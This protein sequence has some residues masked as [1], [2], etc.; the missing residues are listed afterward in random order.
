MSQLGTTAKHVVS[1]AL[2]LSL[3]QCYVLSSNGTH[4]SQPKIGKELQIAHLWVVSQMPHSPLNQLT[5]SLAHT[6][7]LFK[8][9]T[10]MKRHTQLSTHDMRTM[11]PH[12][13]PLTNVTIDDTTDPQTNGATV[14]Q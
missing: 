5:H 2:P 10:L 7:S 11:T 3:M 8:R 1:I 9:L 14:N 13:P 12:N 4:I 6:P